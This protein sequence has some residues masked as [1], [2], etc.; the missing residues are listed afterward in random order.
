MILHLPPGA[1]LVARIAADLALVLHIGGGVVGIGAG[2]ATLLARKGGRAHRWLGNIFFVSMLIMAA[3]GAIVAPLIHQP[4]N[5][6]GGVFTFYLVLTGWLAA[7]GA[8]G[9]VGRLEIAAIAAPLAV[10][11]AMAAFV[12]MVKPDA[13]GM[14]DGVPAPAP[15]VMGGLALLAAAADLSVV[16]RRGLKGGQRLARHLWRMCAGLLMASFSLFIGQPKVF[17]PALRGSPVMFLPELFV[18]GVMVWHL[19][20]LALRRRRALNRTTLLPSREK[21]DAAPA[22]AG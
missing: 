6:F 10:A 20:R 17:P 2:M 19:A 8:P 22:A 15:Y 5:L 21:V 9:A 11:V 13:D 14:R 12:I 1:P 16:L 18:A 7:R 4:N 3:V